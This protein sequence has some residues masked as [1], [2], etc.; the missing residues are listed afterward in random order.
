MASIKHESKLYLSSRKRK[1]YSESP[2]T[3]IAGGRRLHELHV[4]ISDVDD[5]PVS[6]PGTL[7][8][9]LAGM[10]VQYGAGEGLN[11]DGGVPGL[12]HAT[13]RLKGVIHRSVE[14]QHGIDRLPWPILSRVDSPLYTHHEKQRASEK[15][16][17]QLVC[18]K[19]ERTKNADV[20]KMFSFSS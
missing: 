2:Y 11:D 7:T 9:G 18:P 14:R 10:Y 20:D 12:V 1:A 17:N 13:V 5:L 6:S 4:V 8:A 3:Y 15:A 19:R 16:P